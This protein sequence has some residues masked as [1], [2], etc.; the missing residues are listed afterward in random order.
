VKFTKLGG[1]LLLLTLLAA[2][3]GPDVKPA[4]GESAQVADQSPSTSASPTS[5]AEADLPSEG[6]LRKYFDGVSTYTIDSLQ[7]AIQVAQPGS[8]AAAYATYIQGSIQAVV[9]GGESYD[10][11]KRTAQ[12]TDDGYRFC[13][14]SGSDETCYEYTDITGA[15]GKVSNFS[16]NQRP[17][18]NRLAVGNGKPVALTGLDATATFIAAFEASTGSRLFVVVSVKAGTAGIAHVSAKY[19]SPQGQSESSD[20][21]GPDDLDADSLANYVFAF[22]D[23][24]IGGTVT[25]EVD[26]QDFNHTGTVELK[27][28]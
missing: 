11:S 3:G 17:L 14:G 16:V 10:D 12:K 21:S 2:C 15:D 8:P 19:R 24:K 4:S 13:E 1:V 23:A 6:T 22:P 9:D 26:D 28:Q 5:E 27:T 18:T 20:Q 7:E 25:L